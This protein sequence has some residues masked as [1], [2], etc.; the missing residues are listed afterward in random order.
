MKKVVKQQKV[1]LKYHKKKNIKHEDY[2]NVLFNKQPINPKMK[3]IRSINHQLSS[4]KLN[5]ISLSCLI[6]SGTSITTESQVMLRDTSNVKT[7]SSSSSFLLLLGNGIFN[8]SVFFLKEL[9]MVSCSIVSFFSRIY[10]KYFNSF[11]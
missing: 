11:R 7:Y 1:F 5:K 10:D 8:L 4:Y 2:K 3:T 9:R 6:I